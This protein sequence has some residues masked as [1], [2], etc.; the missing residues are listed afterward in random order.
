MLQYELSATVSSKYLSPTIMI[1]LMRSMIARNQIVVISGIF[2]LLATATTAATNNTIQPAKAQ[3]ATPGAPLGGCIS[4]Q[5]QGS[6]GGW[7]AR[8]SACAKGTPGN[9][10]GNTPSSSNGISDFRAAGCR[11]NGLGAGHSDQTHGNTASLC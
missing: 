2:V 6:A 7:G 10:C 5:A 3:C 1:A 8:V 9:E 4:S 11:L